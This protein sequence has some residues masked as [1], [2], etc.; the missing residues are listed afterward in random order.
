MK[1][2]SVLLYDFALRL[3]ATGIKIYSLFNTKAKL[4]SEGRKN[5]FRQIAGKIILNEKIIWMHCASVGEFEQGRPVLEMLK[6]KFPTYRIL[7]TFFSPSAYELRK[8][9]TGA[10]YIFYLPLDSK[11]NAEK[12][13]RIVQPQLAVFVKYEFWYHYL[14]EL[15]QRNVPTL[16]ISAIFRKE[17]L[18]F[19]WYGKFFL[20]LLQ[21][22]KQ[23][24]VQDKDSFQL[25]KDYG[26]NNVTLSSDT[27]FDRVTAIAAQAK[28]VP[29]IDLFKGDNRI[30]I[31][32]STW[33][34]DE[35]LLIRFI[36]NSEIDS[37]TFRFIIVPHEINASHIQSIRQK[38]S[39]T[40]LLFSEL[41]EGNATTA[42]TIIVDN[43]G[44]LSSLYRYAAIAYIGGGFGKGIHNILEAAVYGVPVIF[45]PNYSKFKEAV[46]LIELGGGFS[47][48]SYDNLSAV[49][50]RLITDKEYFN[51]SSA[52]CRSYLQSGTG[53]VK[54]IADYL[55]P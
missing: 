3:Y 37:A 22:Y 49:L 31:G 9:F 45:G 53:A 28:S 12:F 43:V 25:L 34:K 16:L 51:Q 27:R 10:D 33:P 7:L 36:N 13:I 50:H 32:G 23:I 1:F 38:L 30:L 54:Q 35:K 4:W 11:R 52:A 17:Q 19:R 44:M 18:F 15:H 21:W 29:L 41:N 55:K 46:D 26:V 42:R 14:Y 20:E 2:L 39:G 24:F 8:N 6:E 40:S 48:N 5:I 47:I